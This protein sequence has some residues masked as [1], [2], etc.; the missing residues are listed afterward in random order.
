ML[1]VEILTEEQLDA[2]EG[3][4]LRLLEEVGT[5][6]AHARARDVLAAH[7]QSGPGEL[8]HWDRGFV[9]EQI[10]KAPARIALR[11]RNPERALEL[12]GGSLVCAPTGGAPFCSDL[13]RGRREGTLGAHAELVR[14]AHAAGLP[15][16][17]SGTVEASDRPVAIRHLEM[18]YSVLRFSDRPYVSYGTSER[19]ARD[20]IEL[21][22]VACGGRAAIE[23][24]PA[25]MGVVNPNSP[26]VWDEA[27]AGALL[28]WA[29]AGQPVI[30][31]PFLLAGLTAPVSLA[32]A[33]SLQVAEAL[34]GIALAQTIRA[35]TPCLFGSFFTGV[36]M[37]SGGPAPGSP[38]AV[39][40]TLAGGQ[41]ARRYGLP[42]RGG[43]GLCSAN[44]LDARAA[45]ETTMMLWAAALSGSDFVLHAA[46][47]LENGLTA[48][49]EKLVLDAELVRMLERVREG[50]GVGAEE[51][52]WE[53]LRAV[54]PGATFLA[55]EH[56]LAHHREW[57]FRSPLFPAEAYEP[58]LARGGETADR[59]ATARWR[60]LLERYEDPGIDPALD[61]ELKA[62][63]ARLARAAP[64]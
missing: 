18:D 19:R 32:A 27:M 26:L 29:E 5:R 36:D 61:G 54:G 33:L 34:S 64:G 59:A 6:V 17:Q 62:T 16:L 55:S 49:F 40:A 38:E 53:T 56:T 20:G 48:S 58:W 50:I 24:T 9:L 45:A 15:C 39:L 25:L 4:A 1:P 14:L 57:L 11:G 7:G 63:I 2:I 42:Y 46:G 30:V 47:W 43:G 35:G 21:A 8:V 31:T 13:E 51:L 28:A 60:E 3:Q 37:R 12:G 23:R 52:A 41:L 22:A 44:V 10:G